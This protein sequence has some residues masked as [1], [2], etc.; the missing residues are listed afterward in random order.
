[1]YWVVCIFLSGFMSS[2]YIF[3]ADLFSVTFV[4]NIFPQSLV[5]F[6]YSTLSSDD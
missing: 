3:D 5:S 1:M 6:F 4:G 2:F